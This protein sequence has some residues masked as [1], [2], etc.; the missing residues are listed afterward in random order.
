M[1]GG[2]TL[3]DIRPE[4]DSD[5]DGLSN[6]QEYL[7]GTYAFDPEDGFSLSIR[8]V[9]AGR[10]VLEF[11]AIRG[12]S[13]TVQASA[14]LQTWKST[15]FN[16]GTDT[17]SAAPREVYESTDVRPVRILTSAPLEDEVQPRFFKLVVH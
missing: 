17:S 3:A 6:L 13:Y 2:K 15:S 1:G 4:E 12:R 7:A 5:K 8:A 10:S 16:L 9:N 11:T 14:D